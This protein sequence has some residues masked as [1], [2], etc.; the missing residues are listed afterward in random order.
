MLP[1]HICISL[2]L[3]HPLAP[4]SHGLHKLQAKLCSGGNSLK[5]N[6]MAKLATLKAQARLSL[7]VLVVG[8]A[9]LTYMISVEGEL[10]ALPLALVFIGLAAYLISRYRLSKQTT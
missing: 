1:Q 8:I 5:V 10:G 4:S 6:I 9:L 2:I 7:G 3:V